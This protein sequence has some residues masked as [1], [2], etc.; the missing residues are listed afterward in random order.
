M[1]AALIAAP[2]AKD[3]SGQGRAGLP[4]LELP[5]LCCEAAGGTRP[6]ADSV[7]AAWVLLYQAAHLL[8][9]VEDGD[10]DIALPFAAGPKINIA[11]GLLA[12]AGLALC[13]LPDSA[14]AQAIR[15]DF[16]QSV[17]QMCAGQH[18]DLTAK[19]PALEQ[20][21]QIAEAKSGAF[22]ALACRSG[23]RL[24]DDDCARTHL[25]GEFGRHLGVLVQIG[26]DIGGLWFVN[27][28]RSDLAAD[29]RWTLPMAYAV[30]VIPE[31]DGNRLQQL[32]SIR[33]AGTLHESSAGQGR[34]LREAEDEIRRLVIEHGALLYLTIE[35]E[36]RRQQAEAA[37]LKT[38]P[39]PAARDE[40]MAMLSATLPASY[41]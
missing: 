15:G 11:T 16:H 33:N 39:S 40:L 30:S 12:S 23:A 38:D 13:D 1:H 6:R 34:G 36:R 29:H 17:L 41:P 20:C 14:S 8:D 25:F 7:A 9:N 26:D 22:F 28:E 31:A 10:V 37:L 2:P 18:L 21:W 19:T 5:G 3:A 35:A 24:A 27:G 4:Y 32:L